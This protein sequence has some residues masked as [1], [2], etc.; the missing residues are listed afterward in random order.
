MNPEQSKHLVQQWFGIAM[1]SGS[2][3]RARSFA[4]EVFAA[5][6]RDHDGL[7]GGTHTREEFIDA[8]VDR[9]F[10]AFTDI[11]V[12]VE[13][14]FGEGDLVAV[15]YRFEATHTA[16][17]MAVPATGRRIVHTENEIYRTADE[18]I[19]ESWGEGS[20]LSTMRQL[21]ETAPTPADPATA[22]PTRRRVA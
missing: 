7:D 9:V 15:R 16:T 21:R 19:V 2:A 6:F 3:P 14:L 1:N 17:F 8:V 5:D 13:Q 4:T 18:Q 12:T 20:W 10:G 22:S 11:E